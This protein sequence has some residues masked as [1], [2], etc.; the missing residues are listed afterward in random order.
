MAVELVERP[1]SHQLR[2][3][4]LAPEVLRRLTRE[5]GAVSISLYDLCFLAGET[6]QEQL[7]GCCQTNAN[8]SPFAQ[9]NSGIRPQKGRATRRERR[10]GTA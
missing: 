6:W 4:Y 10:H 2:L 9:P 7:A 8:Q 3:A 1:V 5:R